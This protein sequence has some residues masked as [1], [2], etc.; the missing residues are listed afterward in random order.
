MLRGTTQ[1][2]VGQVAMKAV[3]VK[4]TAKS[5]ALVPGNLNRLGTSKESHKMRP[6]KG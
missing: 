5:P 2:R 1:I 6:M 3:E 4:M